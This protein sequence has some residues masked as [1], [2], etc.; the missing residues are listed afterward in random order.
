MNM[1]KK[2]TTVIGDDTN[3]LRLE[4]GC[5]TVAARTVIGSNFGTDLYGTFKKR[6]Y[7]GGW[8]R[9]NY[10]EKS[11]RISLDRD[12]SKTTV[13]EELVAAVATSL[14]TWVTQHPAELTAI[15]RDCKRYSAAV[16]FDTLYEAIVRANPVITSTPAYCLEWIKEIHTYLSAYGLEA[17]TARFAEILAAFQEFKLKVRDLVALG[18]PNDLLPVYRRH[19][20]LRWCLSSKEMQ[21]R[22]KKGFWY[23]PA[24]APKRKSQA[25]A[26]S[27]NGYHDVVVPLAAAAH[28]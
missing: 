28:S 16:G 10:D 24:A 6:R 21:A 19:W 25:G 11:H 22:K 1:G 7:C 18:C 2:T 5:G 3:P 14:S 26:G 12:Y 23:V 20:D 15:C 8:L 4:T 9:W 27:L 17:D 13:P